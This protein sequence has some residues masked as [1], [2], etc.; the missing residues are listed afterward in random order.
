MNRPA[1][2]ALGAS[3]DN[4]AIQHLHID[5]EDIAY[6]DRGSGPTLVLIH[7]L[8]GTHSMWDETI[9][10][11]EGSHR[12]LAWDAIGHGSSTCR[13][14]YSIERSARMGLALLAHCGVESAVCLGISMG[15]QTAMHMA[16][17]RPQAVSALVLADTSLGGR[18]GG[19]A[20]VAAVRREVDQ[21]GMEAFAKSYVTSRTALGTSAAICDR[22]ARWVSAMPPGAYL[23][24]LASIVAQDLRSCAGRIARPTLIIVGAEDTST[25]V[26]AAQELQA[27]IPGSELHVIPAAKHFSNLDNPKAF[28]VLVAD[29]LR[30]LDVSFPLPSS[31]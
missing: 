2:V 29:F 16:L 7:S 4:T 23:S 21:Y 5:G 6:I 24:T 3:D 31:D 12:I 30:R 20:R 26:E 1:N 25:P 22:Y 19:P 27:A 8:G 15:G 17:L 13:N 9:A 18:P 28:N 11:F 10:A 14:E